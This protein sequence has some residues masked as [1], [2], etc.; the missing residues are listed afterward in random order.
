M[1]LL[2]LYIGFSEIL[3]ILSLSPCSLIHNYQ[4]ISPNF[5]SHFRCHGRNTLLCIME[6]NFEA[7]FES[8]L[9]NDPGHIT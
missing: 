1:Y 8:P 5:W 4:I 2:N 7:C 9:L 3:N 6:L